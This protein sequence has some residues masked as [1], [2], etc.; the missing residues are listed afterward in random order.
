MRSLL[1]LLL[2]ALSTCVYGQQL[3]GTVTDKQ[4]GQPVNGAIIRSP[5]G[6]TTS[7]LRGQFSIRV[8]EGDTLTVYK[9]G[10]ESFSFRVWK[11]TSPLKIALDKGTMVLKEVIISARRNDPADSLANRAEFEKEFNY[12]PPAIK[13]VF[14]GTAPRSKSTLISFNLGMLYS[15][16]TKKK[17]RDYRLRQ[18]LLSDEQQRYI[19]RKY[20]AG[21]VAAV[22]GLQ[23]KDLEEFLSRYRPSYEFVKSKPAYEV[24]MYIRKS[25]REFKGVE[26]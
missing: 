15:M 13:D 24:M 23:G 18:K 25:Y 16:I 14:I 17:S 2:L 9:A 6:T 19:D 26:D 7:G 11:I 20:N 8:H 4:T 3:S 21:I 5:S 12:K 1:M 10:Y 22:T